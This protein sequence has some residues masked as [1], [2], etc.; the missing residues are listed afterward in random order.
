MKKSR[1]LVI[2]TFIIGLFCIGNLSFA[3]IINVAPEKMTI[4][5]GIDLAESGDT[6]LVADGIY[7]EDGNVNIDFKG[8]KIT[9]KSENGP[10]ATIID[11]E[12]TPNTRGF[13][14]QNDETHNSILDGFTIKNGIH[15]LGGGIFCDSSS[16]MV[17]NC[18]ISWNTA[19]AA[20]FHAQGGGGIYCFNSDAVFDSCLITNNTAESTFGGGVF[21]DGAWIRD[22]VVLRE[23]TPEPSLLNCTISD[24]NGGGVFCFDDVDPIIQD[25][26]VSQNSGSGIVYNFFLRTQNPIINCIIEQNSDSGVVCSEASSL[27]IMDSIIRQNVGEIGGGIFCSPTSV[28][29]VSNCIIAENIAT[30]SGGGI[31]VISTRGEA[32]ISNCTI[33]RNTANERG[34][35]VYTSIE[36]S[37]FTLSNSIVWGNNSNGTHDEF[38]AIG[39]TIEITSCDIRDGLEG[40]GR[41]P[42][43]KWFIYE[44]NI[45]KDP[46]F[47]NPDRGD[48][49]LSR[50]SPAEGMGAQTSG[51]GTLSVVPRGK[52]LT[53][54]ADIKRR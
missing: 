3:A 40:I 34:G 30:E 15:D 4:Q 31:G 42:D 1:F 13:I 5:E 24:N 26:K 53:M 50:N 46:L 45:D 38:S 11:C 9:V 29:E 7:K 21:F 17:M 43:G 52:Q 12:S 19:V 16:P 54:W 20:N 27:K 32:I 33:T 51:V 22:D 8:K 6:V 49:S 37:H 25:C 28:I 47:V 10:E 36:V 35:G 44:N 41:Q 23:T 18:I 14:F 2:L 39:E 48:Y